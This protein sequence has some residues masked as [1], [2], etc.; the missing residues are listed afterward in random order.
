MHVTRVKLILLSV[1]ASFAFTAVAS[2]SASA[3]EFKWKVNGAEAAA[4]E[5]ESTGGAFTLK[6]ANKEIK[7]TAVTDTGNVEATGKGLAKTILF[8]GCTTNETGCKVKSAGG[9]QKSGEILVTAIP[10]QLV[11]RGGLLADEFK[12]KA[13]G[14]FVTLEFGK[15]EKI[16]HAGEATEKRT[17]ETNCTGVIGYPHTTK[18][19][20]QIAAKVINLANKKEVEL[21]FPNPQLAGNTLEA[22]AVAATLFGIDT[23]KLTSAGELEGR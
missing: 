22:F 8:T 3:F 21:E 16:E 12:A 14:E 4:Q 18:V 1:F 6:A 10:T 20:G 5:V 13:S 2:A 17:L 23:Q 19:E 7:C 11:E 9:K 15:V